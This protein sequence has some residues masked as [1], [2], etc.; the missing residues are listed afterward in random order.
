MRHTRALYVVLAAVALLA[1]TAP[2]SPVFEVATIKLSPG[3]PRK[4][5]VAGDR[6]DFQNVWLKDLVE[7]AYK[8]EPFQIQAPRWMGDQ[9][10]SVLAKLPA[11][12]STDQIPAMLQALLADRLRL[13]LHHEKRVQPVYALVVA[14]GGPKLK[15]PE[16]KTAD[17]PPRAGSWTMTL[18]D[19]STV[20]VNMPR[21]TMQVLTRFLTDMVHRPVLDETGLSG[22]FD[23][24]LHAKV[25]MVEQ[26]ASTSTGPPPPPP[27][28]TSLDVTKGIQEL[29]LRLEPRNASVDFLVVDAAE[30][31]PAGN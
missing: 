6:L 20:R 9:R 7:H 8:V 3:G 14:K 30:R 11:G 10:Y 18:V 5:A 1:Q 24:E 17:P 16:D 2:K 27:P 29:G 19:S 15:R 26:T 12:A 23:I 31:M 25:A 4:I 28:P 13:K 22:E 21:A